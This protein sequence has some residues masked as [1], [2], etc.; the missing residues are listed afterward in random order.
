MKYNAKK[1]L[2]KRLTDMMKMRKE[3]QF[4]LSKIMDVFQST[5]SA[6]CTDQKMPR[7]DKIEKIALHYGVALSSLI[8]P[9]KSDTGIIPFAESYY[10][11]IV[12]FI[13]AGY[14]A[15]AAKNIEGY[16]TIHYKDVENYFFARQR[17][18]HD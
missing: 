7:M 18:Q 13:P 5:V 8:A 16:A 4:D 10:A 6:W 17:G 3:S 11:P 9:Q 12:G 1:F 2:A 15:L 14:P